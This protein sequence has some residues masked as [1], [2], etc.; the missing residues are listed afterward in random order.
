MPARRN[1]AARVTVPGTT[2]AH[3]ATEFRFVPCYQRANFMDIHR[4][5]GLAGASAARGLAR[6]RSLA[7]P[8]SRKPHSPGCGPLCGRSQ[9]GPNSDRLKG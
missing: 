4:E 3:E 8:S 2:L 5:P 1:T 9:F 7:S 6:G